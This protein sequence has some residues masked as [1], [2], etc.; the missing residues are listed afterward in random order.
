LGVAPAVL[1]TTR[2]ADDPGLPGPGEAALAFFVRGAWPSPT[3]GVSLTE[4][5][6]TESERLEVVSELD[7]GASS[8]ATGSSPTGSNSAGASRRRWVSLASGSAS[9]RPADL[10]PQRRPRGRRRGG[11]IAPERQDDGLSQ[12]DHAG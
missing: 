10:S 11:A 9:W 1:I 12:G 2:A 3:F 8:S 4:G 5:R 7:D 6:L